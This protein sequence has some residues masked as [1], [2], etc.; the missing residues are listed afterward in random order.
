M[1]ADFGTRAEISLSSLGGWAASLAG[2]GKRV[3]SF[4][5][6]SCSK[7]FSVASLSKPVTSF[8]S[9]GR[10]AGGAVSS[11]L[12]SL[13]S[14]DASSPLS[15]SETKGVILSSSQPE[16]PGEELE[17]GASPFLDTRGWLTREGGG[18]GGKNHCPHG[19]TPGQEGKLSQ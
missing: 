12:S 19:G 5:R 13:S 11:S 4:F 17:P 8:P 14:E 2:K 10:F 15:D 7:G 6:F 9:L 18:G 16:G 3:V 1:A